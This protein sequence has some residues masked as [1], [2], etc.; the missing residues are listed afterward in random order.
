MKGDSKWGVGGGGPRL[1]TGKG[2]ECSMVDEH[3]EAARHEAALSRG[4]EVLVSALRKLQ[5]RPASVGAVDTRLRRDVSRSTDNDAESEWLPT[6]V[7]CRGGQ[8]QR[9]LVHDGTCLGSEQAQAQ[10]HEDQ[11]AGPGRPQPDTVMV[12]HDKSPRL[13]KN[14]L[15]L[16]VTKMPTL[17]Y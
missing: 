8:S 10:A 2:G 11:D 3:I 12:G 14:P 6:M 15:P 9:A 1:A 4:L 13:Q 17:Q 16:S 7:S 5:R